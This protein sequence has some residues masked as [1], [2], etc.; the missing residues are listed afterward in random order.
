MCIIL[1]YI[2]KRNGNFLSLMLCWKCCM[3]LFYSLE[4]FIIIFSFFFHLSIYH[5]HKYTFLSFFS[6]Q[7]TD[8]KYLSK[9]P[10]LMTI[11]CGKYGYHMMPEMRLLEHMVIPFL[12]LKKLHIMAILICTI[13]PTMYR[14][15]LFPTSLPTLIRLKNLNLIF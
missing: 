7:Q 1:I 11:W 9:Y 3:F 12:V 13:S 10:F 8:I 2:S 5:I 4:Q 14:G 15:L 6:L